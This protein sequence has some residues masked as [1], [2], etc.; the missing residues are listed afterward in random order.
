MKGVSIF[1]ARNITLFVFI[2]IVLFLGS[3]FSMS[4]GNESF[5]EG[6]RQINPTPK[7]V[8]TTKAGTPK[9]VATT[10]A[11]AT[12]R[13]SPKATTPKSTFR[14]IDSSKIKAPGRQINTQY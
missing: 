6:S 7:A 4:V 8:A 9:A 1:S 12:T 5:T 2:L 10:K 11:A 3:M 14:K 13:A